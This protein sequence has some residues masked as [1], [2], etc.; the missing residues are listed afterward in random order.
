M[1]GNLCPLLLAAPE[2]KR[3]FVSRFP[4]ED[5]GI[6][7]EEAEATALG[8]DGEKYCLPEGVEGTEGIKRCV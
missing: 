5:P 4:L 8:P 6:R 1:N 3:N 2:D 7:L